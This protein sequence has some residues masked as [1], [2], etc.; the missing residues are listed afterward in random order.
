MPTPLKRH[1]ALVQYSKEHHFGLLLGWKIRQGIQKN[2]T[3][4]RMADYI[5]AASNVELMPHFHNEEIELF[6]LLQ[7]L[8]PLRIQAE[9]EHFII[10]QKLEELRTEASIEGLVSFT[11]ML[12]EHIR[13]EERQLF[14]HIEQQQSFEVYASAMKAHQMLK[15]ADFDSTWDDAFWK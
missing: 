7:E 11:N 1:E 15:H 5:I 6:V 10:R 2:V 4:Q 3:P 9:K 12:D 13:F 8:D 14:P